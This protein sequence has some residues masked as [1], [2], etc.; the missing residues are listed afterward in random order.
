[1]LAKDNGR[2]A[3]NQFAR[4]LFTHG[5]TRLASKELDWNF[6]TVIERW[7]AAFA[8]EPSADSLM[9]YFVTL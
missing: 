7:E 2:E 1:M 6:K 8:Y 4:L 3:G 5:G 9:A